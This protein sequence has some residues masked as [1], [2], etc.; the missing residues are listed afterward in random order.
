[1]LDIIDAAESTYQDEGVMVLKDD[2]WLMKV[3]D[4]ANVVMFAVRVTKDAVEEYRKTDYDKIGVR[5]GGLQESI[6]TKT[7]PVEMEVKK[8]RLHVRQQGYEAKLAM[9]DP[10]YVSGVAQKAPNLDWCVEI[11]G[12]ISFIK[13]FV[14]RAD[15][16]I[17]PGAFSI[18]PREH[19]LYLYAE[20][21]NESIVK[22]KPWDEFDDTTINWDQG[23]APPDSG[24]FNPSEHKA[25]DTIL[26][27]D[28]AKDMEFIRDEGKVFIDN[29]SPIKILF[30]TVDGV[31]SSY[32]FSPRI[33]NEDKHSS[34]P[35]DA[36]EP[37][38]Q[39]ER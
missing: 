1:M 36:V 31:D 25:C 35:N 4:E 39:V 27:V 13:D 34:T 2:R 19:A 3:V 29:H 37:E 32:F 21:D 22:R 18:S 14:K 23:E 15:K 33:S 5:F 24:G 26:S 38:D 16:I 9:T 30:D 17:G 8:H 12:D 20:A 7:E 11:G 6:F 10:Q 28:Y